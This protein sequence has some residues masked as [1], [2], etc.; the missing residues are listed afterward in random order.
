MDGSFLWTDPFE[1]EMACK[2][3]RT[4]HAAAA[5]APR[6]LDLAG[7]DRQREAALLHLQERRFLCLVPRQ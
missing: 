5:D 4:R 1:I 2:V 6:S 7:D 3:Q